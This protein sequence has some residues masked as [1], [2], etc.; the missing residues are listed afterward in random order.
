MILLKNVPLYEVKTL[1][2]GINK[3]NFYGAGKKWEIF[4][5]DFSKKKNT[6]RTYTVIRYFRVSIL[7]KSNLEKFLS[8]AINEITKIC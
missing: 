2:K 6:D 1:K 3:N 5:C 4:I 7:Q 8:N